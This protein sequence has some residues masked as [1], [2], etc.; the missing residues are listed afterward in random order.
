MS[1]VEGFPA[2]FLKPIIQKI[3]KEPTREGLIDLHLLISVNAASVA[4]NLGGG[5]HGHLNLTMT[6]EEYRAQTGFSFVTPHNPGNYPQIMGNAQEQALGTEKF[7]HNQAL[8]RKYTA[9]G[10]ALNKQIVTAVEPVFLS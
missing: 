2:N 1:S 5:R 4:S 6:D 9:V 7:R 10:G 8:F 3:D